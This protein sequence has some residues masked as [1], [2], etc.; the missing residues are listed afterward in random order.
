MAALF[1]A[2]AGILPWRGA[3]FHKG[4]PVC[5]AAAMAE[6]PLHLGRSPSD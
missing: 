5:G 6:V 2:K 4:E 1:P 3:A